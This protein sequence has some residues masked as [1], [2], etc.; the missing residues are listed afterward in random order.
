VRSPI[1]ESEREDEIAV[2]LDSR[3]LDASAAD[4]IAQSPMTL[5]GLERLGAAIRPDAL[6]AVLRWL[7]ADC[8]VRSLATEIDQAGTRI[9]D[10]VTAVRG[11]TRVDASSV[12]QPVD[13]GGGLTQTLAVLK[14]KARQKAIR[15]VV[16]VDDGLPPVRGV[17]AEL[18]QVWANLIDNALDAAPQGGNVT[19]SAVRRDPMVAV[20]VLDDGTGIPA[21]IQERIFDPFFTTKDVGKGTGL[22]LDIVRRLVERHN[23]DIEVTSVP[24]RTEFTVSL[25]IATPQAPERE[26]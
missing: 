7:A 11:F 20:H 2:W 25:P 21:E 3:G 15:V 24:G 10:L 18:N 13:I 16:A 14:G 9:S 22:G 26:P 17:P 4:A 6:E 5:Q 19:V 1:E 23:G 8:S 12:P